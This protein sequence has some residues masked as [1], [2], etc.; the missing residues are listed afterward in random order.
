MEDTFQEEAYNPIFFYDVNQDNNQSTDNSTDVNKKTQPND[1]ITLI[2]FSY[3][4]FLILAIYMIC[5]ICKYENTENLQKGIWL[6]MYL[7]NNAY[8][9]VSLSVGLFDKFDDMTLYF[10]F[11]ELVILGIGTIVYIVKLGKGLC[12]NAMETI[13]V[14]MR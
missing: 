1:I 12:N 3:P 7:S 6:F 13:S 2:N 4:V 14:L 5:A 11:P 9:I 8:I 10:L